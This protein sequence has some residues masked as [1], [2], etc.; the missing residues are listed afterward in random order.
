[1]ILKILS[2]KAKLLKIKKLM[3]SRNKKWLKR[4]S[5][6]INKVALIKLNS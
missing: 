3:N 4:S 6:K 1:M 2:V 5:L